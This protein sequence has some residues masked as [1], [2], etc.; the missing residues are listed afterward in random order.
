MERHIKR[1]HHSDPELRSVFSSFHD[2]NDQVSK[3]STFKSHNLAIT[4]LIPVFI[5]ILEFFIDRH[6]QRIAQ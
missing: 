3:F 4:V 5:I 6:S 1:S 2:T